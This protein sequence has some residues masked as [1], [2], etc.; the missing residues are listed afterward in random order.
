MAGRV[1]GKIALVTGGAMGLGKADCEML[2]AEGARVIVTDRECE[3]AHKVADSIGGDAMALD[4]TSETQWQEVLQ[5]VQERHGGLE[6]GRLLAIAR[7]RGGAL[8][9]NP[10][11]DPLS[12]LLDQ[13][14]PAGPKRHQR[15]WVR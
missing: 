10:V 8:L 3:Q 14:F 6:E 12:E 1:E 7:R 2:A 11:S 4:V 5:A 9:L 15:K 13:R